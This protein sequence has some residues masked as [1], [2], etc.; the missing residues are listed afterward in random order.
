MCDYAPIKVTTTLLSTKKYISGFIFLLIFFSS[1]LP[2][3]FLPVVGPTERWCCLRHLAWPC[4]FLCTVALSYCG[5]NWKDEI[6]A[7]G[8]MW[9]LQIAAPIAATVKNK[10]QFERF[11]TI[12]NC[13]LSVFL[14]FFLQKKKT[15]EIS[16][17]TPI[18]NPRPFQT[19]YC[20]SH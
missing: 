6:G 19:L 18:I 15:F 9:R 10:A 14:S 4:Y 8:A 13:C 17:T 12:P 1:C 20:F 2:L 5:A 16:D 3:G 7:I 11:Y